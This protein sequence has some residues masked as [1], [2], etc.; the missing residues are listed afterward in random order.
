LGFWKAVQQRLWTGP[1]IKDYGEVSNRSV[2][3]AHRTLSA[4]LSDKGGRR[5]YLR[6]S[7][8][9]FGAFRINFIELDRDEATRLRDILGD[10]LAEM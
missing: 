3:G 6:E 1:V 10:A 2:R 7:W 8:R 4:V 5:V 9:G